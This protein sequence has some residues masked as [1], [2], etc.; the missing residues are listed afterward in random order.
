MSVTPTEVKSLLWSSDARVSVFPSGECGGRYDFLQRQGYPGLCWD[1][2]LEPVLHRSGLCFPCERLFSL[3]SLC[4]SRVR[5]LVGCLSRNSVCG[6]ELIVAH[7]LCEQLAF[8]LAVPLLRATRSDIW[9][10]LPV[11]YACLKD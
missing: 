8:G 10:I 4:L 7:C 1:E 9:L 2:Y 6:L 3:L 5:K 11:A